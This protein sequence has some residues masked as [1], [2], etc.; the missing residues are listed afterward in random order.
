M[1]KVK[2][3]YKI[4]TIIILSLILCLIVCFTV[5]GTASADS[6]GYVLNLENYNDK[7]VEDDLMGSSGIVT[8]INCI[9]HNKDVYENYI[10]NQ[11]G[12]VIIPE[13][14]NESNILAYQLIGF[15]EKGIA[16]HP[17]YLYNEIDKTNLDYEELI[18]DDNIFVTETDTERMLSATNE[19]QIDYM[20]LDASFCVY[21]KRYV[22][23]YFNV[24]SV[25]MRMTLD[26]IPSDNSNYNSYIGR[27]EVTVTP[28]GKYALQSFK[29]TPLVPDDIAVD[30]TNS[31]TNHQ[32]VTVTTNFG[33]NTGIITKKGAS[34]SSSDFQVS[35]GTDRNLSISFGYSISA[36]DGAS[37]VVQEANRVNYGGMHGYPIKVKRASGSDIQSKG[38]TYTGLYYAT[39]RIKKDAMTGG[40][41]LAFNKLA[42]YG[43]VGEPSYSADNTEQ[44][45]LAAVWDQPFNNKTMMFLAGD[46]DG[47]QYLSDYNAYSDL[48]RKGEMPG[49]WTFGE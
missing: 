42:L 32:A 16:T 49:I 33:F 40:V 28:T 11:K 17:I 34:F 36:P 26:Y 13:R 29:M 38:K 18:Y 2:S 7:I 39:H 4:Q 12:R 27:Y 15:S 43:Q 41:G 3:F 30:T 21:V 25:R 10:T 47:S 8:D 31:G 1:N 48:P 35:I 19:D 45:I 5:G 20:F 22:G 44:V 37:S 14:D 6:K 23:N 9:K 46:P 24:G